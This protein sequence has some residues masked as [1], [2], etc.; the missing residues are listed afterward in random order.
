LHSS[1]WK[2]IPNM[3]AVDL[4]GSWNYSWRAALSFLIVLGCRTV[5]LGCIAWAALSTALYNN[6]SRKGSILHWCLSGNITSVL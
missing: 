2:T 4:S 1:A 3:A 5:V 6:N